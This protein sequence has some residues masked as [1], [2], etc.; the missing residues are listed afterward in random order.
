M[1]SVNPYPSPFAS[2]GGPRHWKIW[3]VAAAMIL[4]AAAGTWIAGQ[5]QIGRLDLL[6]KRYEQPI[7][8][9][10]ELA[11]SARPQSLEADLLQG[12]KQAQVGTWLQ[13]TDAIEFVDPDSG[14]RILV[15]VDPSKSHI[16]LNGREL[17]SCISDEIENRQFDIGSMTNTWALVM[18]VLGIGLG[19]WSWFGWEAWRR[20]EKF[21]A[22]VAQTEPEP[23]TVSEI[24]AEEK[25][26]D[27]S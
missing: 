23:A 6:L 25:K 17:S 7:D 22:P 1:N 15:R 24:A 3:A 4:A 8:D 9:Y 27:K 19:V 26:S 2:M 11:S 18:F 14:N 13:T 10:A 21:V 12:C 5:Y 20:R 16:D